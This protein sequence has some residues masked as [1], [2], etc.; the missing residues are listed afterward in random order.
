MTCDQYL[1]R[2]AQD[3][4]RLFAD[5]MLSE[6]GVHKEYSLLYNC[7]EHDVWIS[8]GVFEQTPLLV[9]FSH[10]PLAAEGIGRMIALLSGEGNPVVLMPGNDAASY[11]FIQNALHVI[12]NSNESADM[13]MV[14]CFREYKPEGFDGVLNSCGVMVLTI[15]GESEFMFPYFAEMLLGTSR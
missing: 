13:S 5:M 6:S 15:A 3:L 14:G 1:T 11:G 7:L 2:S 9:N 8:V 12:R 4:P 10:L